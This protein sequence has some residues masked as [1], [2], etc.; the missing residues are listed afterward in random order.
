MANEMVDALK[1]VEVEGP[2]KQARC[3]GLIVIGD[4]ILSGRR[5]D[6]H[7]SKLIELL[8]ERG[9]SLAWAKYVADDPEQI[10]ASLK[11]NFA[12]GDVVFST[13]GI[14]ATPDDHTRQCAAL[15][16]GSKA[17]LHPTARELIAGRIQSMAEGDPIKADLSTPENQ[18]RFKMWGSF[19]LVAK[20]FLIPI[21]KFRVFESKSITLCQAFR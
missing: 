19:R 20:S 6:K 18:H 7:M 3:L 9:L 4:E 2:S 16:L 17:E 10:T 12:S 21:T 13:G 11:D 8:N 5:Q 15:A 1:K 14:G